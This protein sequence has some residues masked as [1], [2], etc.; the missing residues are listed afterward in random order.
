MTFNLFGYSA[1]DR[2]RASLPVPPPDS[3]ALPKGRPSAFTTCICPTK[4]SDSA[5][6]SLNR[7]AE[8][9]YA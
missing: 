7:R 8:V 2:R 3:Y 6:A 4:R 5:V 1:K 9:W